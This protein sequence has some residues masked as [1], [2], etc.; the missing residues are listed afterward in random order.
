MPSK[1][2]VDGNGTKANRIQYIE[3]TPLNNQSTDIASWGT[4]PFPKKGKIYLADGAGAKYTSKNGVAFFF[5]DTDESNV[6]VIL[7]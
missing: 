5:T 4:Y 3:V 1:V 2:R 7:F 6:M